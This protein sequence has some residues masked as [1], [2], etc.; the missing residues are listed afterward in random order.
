MLVKGAARLI[1]ADARAAV[2][3]S[4]S[5]RLIGPVICAVRG[6]VQ[7]DDCIT[8]SMMSGEELAKQYNAILWALSL[9]RVVNRY[10][11]NFAPMPGVFPDYPAPVISC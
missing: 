3:N 10:V 2:R 8:F 5:R 1:L 7:V 9:I 11:G 6:S 4:A